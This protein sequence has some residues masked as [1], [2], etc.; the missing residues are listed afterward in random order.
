MTTI[1]L[2]F[3]GTY[4]AAPDFWDDFIALAL[5]HGVTVDIVTHR[6]EVADKLS[7][8]QHLKAVGVRDI[9]YVGYENSISPGK[10]TLAKER[11]LHYDIWIDD[12]PHAVVIGSSYGADALK[13][14]REKDIHRAP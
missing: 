7:I 9:H 10:L 13:V 5:K 6:H 2:D 3:D 14:W 12:N 1:A 4:S 11:G 8:E